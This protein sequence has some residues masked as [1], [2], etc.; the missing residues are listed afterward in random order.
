MRLFGERPSEAED[1]DARPDAAKPVAAR[2]GLSPFI[3]VPGLLLAAGIL[4]Y[5]VG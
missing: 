1:M 5:F 2:E 4:L 3:W